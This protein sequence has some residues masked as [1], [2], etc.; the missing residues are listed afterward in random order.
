MVTPPI[1]LGAGKLTWLPAD[2]PCAVRPTSTKAEA[3]AVV[4]ER[5]KKIRIPDMQYRNDI[6]K[7]TKERYE[8]LSRQGWLK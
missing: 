5:I 3:F 6:Y 8:I 7:C 1:V 4:K 2:R